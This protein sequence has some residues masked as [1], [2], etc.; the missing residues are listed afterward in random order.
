MNKPVARGK[1]LG[2]LVTVVTAAAIIVA[3]CGTAQKTTAP[4]QP[5]TASP[6]ASFTA[7]LDQAPSLNG[8]PDSH[9]MATYTVE[10]DVTNKSKVAG[11]PVCV[12]LNSVQSTAVRKLPGKLAQF[13]AEYLFLAEVRRAQR[14]GPSIVDKELSCP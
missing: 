4:A 8:P 3:G 11:T 14:T 1:T 13:S 6:E 2:A 10:F 12:L 5:S 9:G 7:R